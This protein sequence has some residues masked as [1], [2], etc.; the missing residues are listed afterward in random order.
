MWCCRLQNR[1]RPFL[2]TSTANLLKHS[3]R[4][5]SRTTWLCRWS[6]RNGCRVGLLPRNEHAG[7]ALIR[8]SGLPYSIVRATQILEFIKAIADFSTVD[9]KVRLPS[10][11]IQP[12]ASADVAAGV[13]RVA[14]G[15]P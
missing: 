10:A 1:W 9:D 3:S 5:G 14:V 8:E 15:E 4:R 12:M 13:G 7:V 11:P 2:Q 6:A